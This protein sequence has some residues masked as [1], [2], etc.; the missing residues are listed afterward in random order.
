MHTRKR[1]LPWAAERCTAPSCPGRP[2]ASQ[3]PRPAPPGCGTPSCPPAPGSGAS[4]PP[5]HAACRL[6]T[7]SPCPHAAPAAP[8]GTCPCR[9]VNDWISKSVPK[10]SCTAQSTSMYTATRS[11]LVERMEVGWGWGGGRAKEGKEMWGEGCR[12]GGG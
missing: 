2:T 3:P 4:C 6:A 10:T 8:G 12:R 7:T 1:H 9:S 11:C 5:P